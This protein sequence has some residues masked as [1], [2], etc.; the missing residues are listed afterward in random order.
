[1]NSVYGDRYVA[2]DELDRTCLGWYTA[3]RAAA[4]LCLGMASEFL[5]GVLVANIGRW[6]NCAHVVK[7]TA[8]LS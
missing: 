2:G 3:S 5:R 8:V 1:M 7:N 6:T 4:M